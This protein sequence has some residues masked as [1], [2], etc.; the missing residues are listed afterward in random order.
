MR[1]QVQRAEARNA[2]GVTLVE[3][4]VVVAIASIL[5]A[6]VFPS[7]GS[8]LGTMELKSAATRVAG[9]ARYARDQAV[10]HQKTFEFQIAPQQGVFTV[11]DLTGENERRY[12]LPESV[13]IASLTPSTGAEESVRRFWFL[14]DGGAPA[15]EI[16]LSNDRRELAVIGDPLTGTARVEER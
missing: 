3:M 13:R 12:E 2:A 1:V 14:P 9:A 15:F 6:V 11:T 10:Y 8:G 5:L 7:V 16:V 4:L